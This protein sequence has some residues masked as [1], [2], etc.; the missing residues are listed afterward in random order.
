M[1]NHNIN[2]LRIHIQ[3]DWPQSPSSEILCIIK[4]APDK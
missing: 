4:K 1:Q 3:I 2:A